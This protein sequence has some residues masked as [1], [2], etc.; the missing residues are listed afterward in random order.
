MLGILTLET[1]FP[2]VAGD[3]GSPAT[4]EFPVRI[5]T[6]AGASVDAVVHRPADA[7]LPA[8]VEAG[9]ALAGEGCIGIV[10]TCGFLARWQRALADALPVPVMTSAL[11]QVPLIA[12]T[13]ACSRRV[14][15]VTYCAADLDAEVLDGAGVDRATPIAGIDPD[16]YFARTIRDGART[17]DAARMAADTVAA[18]RALV[19][20]H[21]DVGAI[22]LECANMPPYRLAVQA[23][24]GLPVFDAAQVFAWF[25]AGLAGYAR[26]ELW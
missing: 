9:R 14:G 1:S 5:A 24:V 6:V 25:H 26:A 16:G 18:A 17:I 21:R 11:L 15:I 13:L 3:V 4:F 8:F 2:R 23:A 7:L 12:R 10:T 20:T 19:A 22:V